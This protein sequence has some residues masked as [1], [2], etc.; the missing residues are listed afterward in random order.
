MQSTQNG[1]MVVKIIPL[2]INSFMEDTEIEATTNK[3]GREG[4]KLLKRLE[5][6]AEKRTYSELWEGGTLSLFQVIKQQ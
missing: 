1:I 2:K 3:C 5:E 4:I 6:A